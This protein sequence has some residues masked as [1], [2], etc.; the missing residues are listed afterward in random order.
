MDSR[1]RAAS[2]RIRAPRC[3]STRSPS[4]TAPSPR[5]G[6]RGTAPSRVAPPPRSGRP[7]PIPAFGAR[8]PRGR[9]G[10]TRTAPA[11]PL[12]VTGG[13]PTCQ[14]GGVESCTASQARCISVAVLG[15]VNLGLPALSPSLAAWLGWVFKVMGGFMVASGLFT[16]YVANTTLRAR[17]A[18]G[19]LVIVTTG[20]YR[21]AGW[22]SSTS[23]STR[24]SCGRSQRLPS[25][26]RWHSGCTGR[27][28][29]TSRGRPDRVTEGHG[30]PPGPIGTCPEPP[31]FRNTQIRGR[32]VTVRQL[33][34]DS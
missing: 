16:A 28:D 9:R 6:R 24:T 18:G 26:G 7:P 10:R 25:C 22:Q 5:V 19:P 17:A 12:V 29:A 32:G 30:T 2:H 8:R 4:T 3:G 20:S 34:S 33:E 14:P 13:R 23:R 27:R 31:R 11:V 1:S 21:S 15:F